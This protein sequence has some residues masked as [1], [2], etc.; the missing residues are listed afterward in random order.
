[1]LSPGQWYKSV[2]KTIL[3][4]LEFRRDLLKRCEGNRELQAGMI[5][6]CRQDC[7][8]FI[9]TFVWQFNPTK[10]GNEVGPFITWPFQDNAI[11]GGDVTEDMGNGP[12][13]RHEYGILESIVD[14]K[15]TRWPKSREMGVSWIVLL[16]ILWLSLFHRNKKSFVLSRDE[17]AVDRPD[18]PDSLFWKVRFI[19]EHLPDWMKGEVRSRKMGFHFKR[20]GSNIFGEA[21]TKDAGVGGRA[22][23]CLFDEFGRFKN[24][25]DI[26]GAT[27]SMTYCRVFVFTHDSASSMAYDLCFDEQYAEM[28]QI[29]TH[30]SQHP[31]KKKGLYRYNQDTNKID[32]FDKSYEYPPDF[33]FNMTGAPFGGPF[34]GLRSPW[35]DAQCIRMPPR[36][37]A[38][39]LDI[40]PQG[41][42]SLFFSAATIQNLKKKYA[43][44]PYW[45]GDLVYDKEKGTPIELQKNPEGKLKLWVNPRPGAV[46]PPGVYRMGFD[47]AAGTG[48]T[49]SCISA[50]NSK[51]GEKIAEFANNSILPADFAVYAVALARCLKTET[52]ETAMMCWEI[53][54]SQAFSRKVIELGYLNVYYRYDEDAIGKA[55]DNAR[56]PGMNTNPKSFE[57]AMNAYREALYKGL[58]INRSAPALDETLSFVYSARGIE[59]KR[60]GVGEADDQ[61]GEGVHHGDR[62]TADYL[63]WHVAKA[64]FRLSSERE[65]DVD[66]DWIDPR[67]MQG[68]MEM[69]EDEERELAIYS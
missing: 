53:Q 69:H 62:V 65:T 12:E 5:E 50:L 19:L 9:N 26:Y 31:E 1:M 68:R 30:W 56:R 64:P 3:S 58:F 15:D 63:C 25:Y 36:Y 11:I 18:D 8:F 10:L 23:I 2:P 22:T 46:F 57:A 39:H 6:L 14:Q 29:L 28:R 48:A 47:V 17:D 4:N 37:V 43:V 59:F 33:K 54:G 42:S 7:L 32:V 41:A 40:N 49:P 16:I 61:S 38:L 60:R 27:A 45:I 20:T 35:Y 67:S 51:S 52:G 24:G 13:T 55:R 44:E 34:P 21:N 66:P